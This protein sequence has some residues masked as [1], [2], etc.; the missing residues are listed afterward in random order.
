[1]GQRGG[2]R[3]LL[4]LMVVAAGLVL[5][6]MQDSM[7][8]AVNGMIQSAQRRPPAPAR[9]TPPSA[10]GPVVPEQRRRSDAVAAVSA[11]DAYGQGFPTSMFGV[12]VLDR[13]TGELEVG[14][15]GDQPVYSASL[16]K[17]ILV[18]DIL[19]RR[20]AGLLVTSS[21]EALM[22]QALGPSDDN[23]MNDLWARFD[24]PGAV[25]RVAQQLGLTQTRPPA[26][27]PQ[28]GET[29]VSARDLARLFE[30]VMSGLPPQD[31]DFI[32]TSLEAAPPI[33]AGGFD[34]SFGLAAAG[35]GSSK[36]AAVKPGWMCCQAE[37][38]TLHSVG[39]VGSRRF[40][41]ALLSSQPSVTGYDGARSAL[42]EAADRA[43]AQLHE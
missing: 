32:L 4:L 12:A 31:R 24:G 43:L 42:T 28:W 35:G 41:V 26:A 25:L 40:V 15:G 34:Q 18:V 9:A 11:V 2:A 3:T 38:T 13:S 36:P 39:V 6:N 33:A 30:H 5:S 23:A 20:D 14:A 21:D 16:V 27:A 8:A 7:P 19:Q 10:A 29:L 1:M 22:R 37:Q 17:L